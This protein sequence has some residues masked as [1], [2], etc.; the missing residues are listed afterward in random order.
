[1]AWVGFATRRRILPPETACVRCGHADTFHTKPHTCAWR[2]NLL[3]L[4]R[5]CLCEG[6]V[7]LGVSPETSD[8]APSVRSPAR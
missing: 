5:H 2:M 4:W 6:Y 3:H 8:P 7:P 1:M